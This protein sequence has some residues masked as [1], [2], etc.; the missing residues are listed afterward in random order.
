MMQLGSPW[1]WQYLIVCAKSLQYFA[2]SFPGGQRTI[3]IIVVRNVVNT[4]ASVVMNSVKR[5]VPMAGA[6]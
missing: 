5:G 1:R 6:N 3:A 2:E 4:A